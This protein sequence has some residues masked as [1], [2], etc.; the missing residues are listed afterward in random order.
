MTD[1]PLLMIIVGFTAWMLAMALWLSAL[2]DA[3]RSQAR[4]RDRQQRVEDIWG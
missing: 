4:E 3:S 1:A 2:N